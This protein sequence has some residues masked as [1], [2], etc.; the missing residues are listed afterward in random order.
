VPFL[1]NKP[2]TAL[3]ASVVDTLTK[4]VYV[5]Q[6]VIYAKHGTSTQENVQAVIADMNL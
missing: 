1:T 6:S 2:V 3:P 5:D 4:I